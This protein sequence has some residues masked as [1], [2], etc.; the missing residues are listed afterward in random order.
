MKRE[1]LRQNNRAPKSIFPTISEN[2]DNEN[3]L[4]VKLARNTRLRQGKMELKETK[5]RKKERKKFAA[6]H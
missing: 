4:V 1:F 2:V 6:K 3:V 5:E